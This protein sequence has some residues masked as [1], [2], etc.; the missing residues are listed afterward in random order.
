MICLPLKVINSSERKKEKHKPVDFTSFP[1]L[2]PDPDQWR[3]SW[4]RIG[5]PFRVCMQWQIISYLNHLFLFLLWLWTGTGFTDSRHWILGSSKVWSCACPGLCKWSSSLLLNSPLFCCVCV[6]FK[7]ISLSLIQQGLRYE[8]LR[9]LR[10]KQLLCRYTI[11]LMWRLSTLAIFSH[12]DK[13][14]AL[15]H[16]KICQ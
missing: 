10:F 7:V 14:P 3:T 16:T 5:I 12:Q 8:R 11:T 6:L 13:S 1:G 15:F 9:T 2:D 4:H